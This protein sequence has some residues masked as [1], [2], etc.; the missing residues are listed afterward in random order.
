[1]KWTTKARIQNLIELLPGKLS[2]ETYYLMQKK[3]GKLYRSDPF[4]KFNKV[5]KIADYI[6]A[7][8]K[9]INSKVFFELGTGY[10]LNAP[11]AL[12]L[13]GANKI[14]TVD[15]N[16]YLK[17]ELIQNDILQL[18]AR[19]QDIEELFAGAELDETRYSLFKS[20]DVHSMNL[21][22][23][24]DMCNIDFRSPADARD[25]SWIA[26]K[27]IDYYFSNDVLE[28]IPQ[29]VISQCFREAYRVLGKDGLMIHLVDF[30]DHFSHSDPS[31]NA[32]N[33]LKYNDKDWGKF[34]NNRYMYMNR[35]RVD[36]IGRLL[37]DSNFKLLENENEI[38]AGLLEQLENNSIEVDEQFCLKNNQHLA[39]LRGW[40]VCE[41]V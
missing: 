26:D 20:L 13:L 37:E 9:H 40:F 33:F 15:L 17:W 3:F 29:A 18:Q 21:S 4:V 34:A 31:I 30:T 8:N 2:Y 36:D 28:H 1:M 11:L 16:P 27:S 32:I 12:W 41:A 24:L 10:R 19:S 23:F 7:Q 38:D 35:A 14:I 39:T 25:L 22:E 5:K 6:F